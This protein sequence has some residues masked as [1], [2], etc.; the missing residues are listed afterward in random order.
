M[1]EKRFNK[2]IEDFKN[3][4]LSEHEKETIR[5]NVMATPIPSPYNGLVIFHK[6][7]QH[8]RKILYALSAVVF[9]SLGGKLFIYGAEKSV[10]GDLLY[11]SKINIIE[12][13]YGLLNN[14]PEEKA[15]FEIIKATRRLVEAE[16]LALS[17]K[18]NT[19]TKNDLENKFKESSQAFATVINEVST[20]TMG[21]E[22]LK[23]EFNAKINAH[24]RIMDIIEGQTPSSNKNEI[25]DFKQTIIQN[26][27]QSPNITEQTESTST[28]SKNIVSDS[29]SNKKSDKLFEGQAS[30]VKVIIKDVHNSIEKS[31]GN[32]GDSDKFHQAIINDSSTTVKQAEQLLNQ[33]DKHKQEGNYPEAFIDLKNSNSKGEEA[34]TSIEDGLKI[35]NTE[36]ATNTNTQSATTTPN[37]VINPTTPAINNTP[38]TENKEDTK[39]IKV[40]T[41]T[42][43]NNVI[44]PTTPAINNTPKTENNRNEERRQENRIIDGRND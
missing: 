2:G 43:N 10:P 1:K 16:T 41:K 39:V 33:A 5:R 11:A 6:I 3:I 44:N 9:L 27:K 28:T 22:Q 4:A 40:E 25:N 32:L 12:P 26:V 13:L 21:N 30:A 38:K 19:N 29:S 37:N 31:K 23:L 42:E 24:M 36:A 7:V 35:K 8:N 34:K 20:S 15:Q 18:L 14:T 17:G